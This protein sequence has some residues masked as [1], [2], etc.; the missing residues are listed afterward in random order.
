MKKIVLSIILVIA[1]VFNFCLPSTVYGSETIEGTKDYTIAG[2]DYSYISHGVTNSKPSTGMETRAY[3]Q[4]TFSAEYDGTYGIFAE[5]ASNGDKKATVQA[6]FDGGVSMSEEF[7]SGDWGKF[8][9]IYIGS[10]ALGSGEHTLKMMAE[11][12]IMRLKTIRI[13]AVPEKT[14]QNFL[15]AMKN[16]SNHADIRNVLDEFSDKLVISYNDYIDELSYRRNFDAALVSLPYNSLIETE[17]QIFAMLSEELKNPLVTFIQNGQE[18]KKLLKGEFDVRISAK[19]EEDVL[20]AATLYTDDGMSLESCKTA[21]VKANTETMITGLSANRDNPLFKLIF[22]ENTS[23]LRPVD[24]PEIMQSTVVVSPDAEGNGTSLFSDIG[25]AVKRAG[26]LKKTWDR[27]ITILLDEGEHFIDETVVIDE[28]IS[29]HDTYG[30]HFKS[31]NP[32]SPATISG[33]YDVRDWHDTDGDGIYTA[34]L[35]DTITDVRQLYINEHPA[36]RAKAD[37]YFLADN[38][39]DNEENNLDAQGK[40]TGYTED[41]FD[42][43]S[44]VFPRLYK[45]QDAEIAYLI[46]WTVQRL[47][48]EDI[49]YGDDNRALIKMQQPYYSNALTMYC[50]GGVQPTIG[51]R[52]TIENDLSLLDK[53]GEYYFDK[54]TRKI[55]YKPFPEEDLSTARTVVAKTEQLITVRG[56]SDTSKVTNITFDNIRFRYGGYYTTINREGAVSFQAENLANAAAGLGHNPVSTGKGR[57]LDAQLTVENARGIKF[58]DCDI[59]CMGSSALRLGTAVT[60]SSVTGCVFADIGGGALSVGTW[61]GGRTIA[62]R[63]SIEN[64]VV[65]RTGL[66]FMFCPALSV[67][68]AKGVN[69]IHNTI[70][71]TPYSAISVGW[72]WAHDYEIALSKDENGKDIYVKTDIPSTANRLG[73]GGHNISYNRVYDISRTVVDGGHVYNLGY[74][75]DSYITNN[76]FTDSPD[77]GGVYL[78]TGASNLKINNNVFERCAKDNIAFG[79]GELVTGNVAESNWADKLQ[80]STTM[81]TGEGCS[82]E[83][84]TAVTDGNW[85]DK[86]RSIMSNA[87]VESEYTDNLRVLELPAWRT[88]NHHSYLSEEA[89]EDGVININAADLHRYYV[90]PADA[91][92]KTGPAIYPFSGITCIGDFR[93]GEWAQYKVDIPK[94][95]DYTL[96]VQY[97]RTQDGRVNVYLSKEELDTRYDYL[98]MYQDS[99]NVPGLVFHK[100]LIPASKSANNAYIPH[101]FKDTDGINP[102]VFSLEKGTYYLRLYN[103]SGGFNFSRFKFTPV[104]E[105]K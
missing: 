92:N 99:T 57:T 35:P 45:P 49:V 50:D 70:A 61:E 83:L 24:Y 2:N 29:S 59:S 84:P 3:A 55:Y 9:E 6:S 21:Y 54:D 52:F 66:D 5:V 18:V 42:M 40:A 95:G 48:V 1:T 81:W 72:G 88:I 23:T 69:L 36:Q 30:I 62:E 97:S 7:S 31:L 25:E 102:K 8:K 60:D 38:R 90:K 101:V 73:V 103:C 65:S 46:L 75:T 79:K 32:E 94:S 105:D 77:Y 44:S 11:K 19:F 86:A 104:S 76:Y 82:F 58:K 39:W 63:I 4:Y 37:K 93:Q 33:G 80:T 10:V 16:A 41:G 15:N 56:S 53:E 20:A 34:S 26:E 67:Y 78:D 28:S 89:L 98:V 22:I 43:Y 68:Y 87:G 47:P 14:E 85:P 13:R 64:N 12:D 74:M 100:Y 96:T 27:D 91:G 71:H 17:S 51:Q